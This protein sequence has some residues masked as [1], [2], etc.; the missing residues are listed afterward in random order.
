VVK[1]RLVGSPWIPA[2][3][4]AATTCAYRY[5]SFQGFNN[6][7]F[8]HVARA[9]QMLLGE[10]PVRDYVESGLP[11]MEALSAIAQLVGGAGLSS[12]IVLTCAT[13]ALAS[14]FMYI[15]AV[16][17]GGSAWFAA[18]AVTVLVIAY[19]LSYSYPKVLPYA[20]AFLAAW[21]YF[22]QPTRARLI[23]L[24]ATI[25]IAFLFRHDHGL[26][27][28]AGVT[29]ALIANRRDSR[30][31][32]EA[33]WFVAACVALV[34][35]YLVWVQ[36]YEGLP[37]YIQH[38]RAFTQ[39]EMGKATWT[40]PSFFINR[41]LPLIERTRRHQGPVVHVRWTPDVDDASL[42]AREAAHGLRRLDPIGP[43]S[44]QY[45]LSRWSTEDL[46]ALVTD[47][48]IADTDGI[49]RHVYRLT[50]PHIVDEID[51]A[52]HPEVV[53]N[54]RNAVAA[55]YYLSWALPVAALLLLI[56]GTVIPRAVVPM[57]VLLIVVQ[58]LMNRTMLRDPLATRVRDVVAPMAAL[59]ALLC[60][61][62]WQDRPAGTGTIWRRS[63][64]AG[65]MLLAVTAAALAGDLPAHVEDMLSGKR[66]AEDAV[67]DR[68]TP[69]GR[70]DGGI[71]EY[72]SACSPKGARFL[73]LTFAPEL[74]FYTGHGFAGGIESLVPGYYTT[75][76]DTARILDRLS[77][78]DVPFTIMD[79]ETADRFRAGYPRLMQ[80]VD[81]RFRE[82]AVFPVGEG[83]WRIILADSRRPSLRVFGDRKLPCFTARRT[84]NR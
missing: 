39:T 4:L 52:Y 29:V 3:F 42:A 80:Y 61:R 75:A 9:Q 77:R 33:G 76:A 64:A 23:V 57:T 56:P 22:A 8:L 62:Y 63:I 78:E 66:G 81:S 32:T 69:V 16:R 50:S 21:Y 83:K 19:P 45:E 67:A 24:A 47:A 2:A 13:F 54:T 71:I 70:V 14:L 17:L 72:L 43:E 40:A 65:T 60:G 20:T 55:L 18:A 1:S 11:L 12:E 41:D 58:L 68:R 35:P 15:L 6:D 46:R 7:H 34:T 44:W 5:L 49:D 51:T 36:L 25:V 38:A 37:S 82:V 59:L 27:L 10:L 79:N 74:F 31:W 26:I 73:P 48:A 28:G 30:P 53:F 84:S